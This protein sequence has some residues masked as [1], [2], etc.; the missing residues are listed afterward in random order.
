MSKIS[1][2]VRRC[3]EDYDMIQDGETVAIGVS[4]GKDSLSLL[5]ALADLRHY[6]PKRFN[7][8]AITIDMG[9]EGADFSP[10]AEICEKLSVPFTLRSTNAAEIIFEKR[11]EKNPCA[12]CAKMRRGMINDVLLELDIKKIALAHS[13][14]DA[15]ETYLMSLLYEGRINC[16]QPVTHLDRADTYQIRPMLYVHEETVISLAKSQNLPIVHNPCPKNGASKREEI[17]ILLKTLG[18]DYP[19]IKK[20]IF[21]AMQRLPL[22]GWGINAMPRDDNRAV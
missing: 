19:D 16:F 21:G 9:F 11:N 13:F 14:D 7:L 10:V 3:I 2:R 15:V 6:Y 18:A 20:K 17:K 8:H 1:G 4:G 22:D 12:L 5:Y